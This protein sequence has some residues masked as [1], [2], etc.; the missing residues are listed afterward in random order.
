MNA[1][2]LVTQN[3][4]LIP[5][6]PVHLRALIEGADA[7]EKK[8]GWAPAD[9][10]R[11]FIVSKDVSPDWLAQLETATEADPWTHGFAL[12]HQATGRVIGM[13]SFKG[14]PG[15]DG[16][17]EVAYGVVPD[18]QNKG[19]ATEATQ[20]LV[21]SA[22][23]SGRV[24]LVRAHTLPEANASTRVLKKCGFRHIGE[25]IDPEDGRVWRWEKEAGTVV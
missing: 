3:L 2:V 7:Y 18:Y 21:A 11:D 9:G 5:H 14:P 25:V 16:V 12:L 6:A 24:R 4:R 23:G 17:V 10:L 13:G 15:A 19:Y 22:F 1:P 20:A 8:F